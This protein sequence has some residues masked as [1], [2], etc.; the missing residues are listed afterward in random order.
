MIRVGLLGLGTVGVG[1]F[2]ILKKNKESLKRKIGTELE[3]HKILVN[4]ID[5]KRDININKS[6]LTENA[7]DIL[8]NPEIDMVVE[9]IGGEEPAYQY[10]IDAINNCKSVV[11]A[12]KL[13]IAKYEREILKLASEKAVNVS[14]EGSVAGGIPIIRPLKDSYAANRIEKLYGILNGTT[15]YILTKM[16][17]EKRNFNDVLKEAQDL[18]FAERD[19][20]SDISGQD[21]AY[22]ISILSS[23]AYETSIDINNVF[24]EG[25]ENIELED[26]EL[27]DELGY[28]IKL[29]AIAK[30]VDDGLDIRVHP[31]FISKDHPLALV[32]DVYNAIYLHGDAVGDV[33][34]YGK[35]AGQMPTASAVVADIIQNGRNIYNKKLEVENREQLLNHNVINIEQVDNSFY[36]RLQVNDK[37]GVLAQIT[38]VL[39]DNEVSLAAVIQKH[40]L[41]TV[42]PIVLITH[43]VKEKNMIKSLHQ[44]RELDDVMLINNVIRVEEL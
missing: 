13:V 39:G 21:A 34:S 20:S 16:T 14:F 9:L 17:R 5:K 29:L 3:I 24:V 36:L 15:N 1:V 6:L 35:G 26:I 44:L 30:A 23:I 18:G 28:V 4:N 32:N 41:T 27:A 38:R 19:P 33:M 43:Q 8:E 37:P 31:A 12:N 2:T 11:T 7:A 22:K 25:I 40:R 42:V 10:I